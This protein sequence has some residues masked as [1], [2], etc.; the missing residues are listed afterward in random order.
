MSM[1]VRLIR[2]VL[3]H[4]ANCWDSFGP[5]LF[6]LRRD[7]E[8]KHALHN[9]FPGSKDAWHS[10][11]GLRTAPPPRVKAALRRAQRGLDRNRRR[12]R[13]ECSSGNAWL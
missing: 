12:R 3:Y 11:D 4:D 8:N 2:L 5:L 10:L 1:E 13:E 9:L 7:A 6:G